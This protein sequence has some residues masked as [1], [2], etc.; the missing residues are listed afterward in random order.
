[1]SRGELPQSELVRID[2]A[3]TQVIP[4]QETVLKMHPDLISAKFPI[5]STIPMAA[6]CLQ[7]CLDMMCDCRFALTECHAHGVYYRQYK[8]PPNETTAV[9]MEKF[10]LE[11]VAFRLYAAAEH[12]ASALVCMLEISNTDLAAFTGKRISNQSI[13]GNYLAARRAG[14]TITKSVEKL[15]L[16]NEWNSTMRYRGQL[17]HEQPPTVAGLGIFFRRPVGGGSRWQFDK[18][19]G[20]RVLAIGGGDAPEFSIQDVTSFV[21]KGFNLL[22]SVTEE[23]VRYYESMIN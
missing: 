18:T 14:H 13:V 11:D 15:A 6:I 8:V 12:L 23:C 22:A 10:F 9:Y 20:I 4:L 2:D 7:D 16:S 19:K 17:V 3:L 5:D 1:M 21:E